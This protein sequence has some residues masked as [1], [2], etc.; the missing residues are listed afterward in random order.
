MSA[1]TKPGAHCRGEGQRLDRRAQRRD[2]CR[3][4]RVLIPCP[5]HRE[6]IDCPGIPD[7]VHPQ[8]QRGLL[9]GR[10]GCNA[11]K[12]NRPKPVHCEVGSQ[13]EPL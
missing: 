12:S 7:P 1:E 3:R 2:G 8:P 11:E 4:E 5:E 6:D 9:H 13:P 10:T